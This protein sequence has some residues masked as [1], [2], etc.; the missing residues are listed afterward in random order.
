MNELIQSH[1]ESRGT[2]DRIE[3]KK[4]YIKERKSKMLW[5]KSVSQDTEEIEQ[6]IIK[7]G[8]ELNK[9]YCDY[10]EELADI[11]SKVSETQKKLNLT[12]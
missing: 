3:L 10:A 11:I 5:L 9:L 12:F 2:L 8:K 4:S 1:Q 6:E 7:M